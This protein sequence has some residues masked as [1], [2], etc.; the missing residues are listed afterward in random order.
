MPGG[1]SLAHHAILL[2]DERLACQRHV[3]EGLCQPLEDGTVTIT[4]VLVGIMWRP[5]QTF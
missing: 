3:L 5:L 2:L 1:V 4:S